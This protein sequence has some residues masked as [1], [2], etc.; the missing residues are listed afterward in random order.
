MRCG[1][2]S[3]VEEPVVSP[4]DFHP[5]SNGEWCPGPPA[6]WQRRAQAWLR[7]LVEET[8]RRLGLSRR[9]FAE[10]A[11]GMAASLWVLNQTGCST[12]GS[13]AAKGD[14]GGL[15]NADG[16]GA[17]NPDSVAAGYDVTPDMMEDM[18]KAR[19]RLSGDE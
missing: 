18:A 6:A 1:R 16:S 12:A 15:P 2:K 5:A 3:S 4:V 17:A 7:R 14:G 8:H 11:C 19:E 10:S 13:T 9:Q